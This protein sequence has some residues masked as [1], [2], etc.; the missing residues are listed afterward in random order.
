[1]EKNPFSGAG[2]NQFGNESSYISKSG[3]GVDPLSYMVGYAL[4]KISGG[5]SIGKEMMGAA[6]PP[7]SMPGLT[8]PTVQGGL[9]PYNPTYGLT[10]PKSQIDP[11]TITPIGSIDKQY[12][13]YDFSSNN[14]ATNLSNISPAL[15]F[16]NDHSKGAQ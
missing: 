10:A 11:S 9:A 5:S 4:D 7:T 14:A 16:W 13:T 2:L 3:S 12:P 1:M 15:S 8:Q 6:K